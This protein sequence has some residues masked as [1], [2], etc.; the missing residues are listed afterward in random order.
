MAADEGSFRSKGADMKLVDNGGRK[1]RRLPASI[2]PREKHCDRE[3]ARVRQYR[4]AAT[5]NGDPAAGVRHRGR[6]I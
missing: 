3:C 4:S 1:R 6:N 2:G 5:E